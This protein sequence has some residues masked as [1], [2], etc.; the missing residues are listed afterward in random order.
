MALNLLLTAFKFFVG[1]LGHSQ[2]CIADAVHSLS[3]FLTDIVVLAGERYWSAPADGDV[4]QGRAYAEPRR[5]D[6]VPQGRA[7]S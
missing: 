4:P 3:D 6:P 7:H 5:G 1:I 2:A